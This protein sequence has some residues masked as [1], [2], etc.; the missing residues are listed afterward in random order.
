MA[1]KGIPFVVGDILMDYLFRHFAR[2]V[3]EKTKFGKKRQ[4]K[5][6][7]NTIKLWQEYFKFEGK[8]FTKFA[9]NQSGFMMDYRINE[10]LILWGSSYF[11]DFLEESGIISDEKYIQSQKKI[12]ENAKGKYNK[13]PIDTFNKADLWHYDFVHSWQPAKGIDMETWTTEQ[14]MFRETY[15][16]VIEEKPWRPEDNDMFGAL[17]RLSVLEEN[18]EVKKKEEKRPV[19]IHVGHYERETRKIGRNEKV[20]VEYEDG[21]IKRN[22]K[23]K[24]V[25]KDVESGKCKLLN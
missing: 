13:E 14:K 24:R 20:D 3:E 22:V 25:M 11:V 12:I 17:E 1:K 7:Y 23:Y 10:V 15:D 8:S 4:I 2:I 19:D 16:M 5:K 9:E 6:H 21:T 18:E